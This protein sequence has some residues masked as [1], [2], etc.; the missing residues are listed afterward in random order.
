MH[1]VLLGTAGFISAI[2][3]AGFFALFV[4]IVFMKKN[5]ADM[6]R[7]KAS[8]MSCI[9]EETPEQTR[10]TLLASLTFLTLLL[11]TN[12][13]MMHLA[14]P[15]HAPTFVLGYCLTDLILGLIL[16]FDC[17]RLTVIH[18]RNIKA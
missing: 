2:L 13:M 15:G 5:V 6:F 7:K 1:T 10:T 3:V 11:V 4:G 16:I 9:V 14:Q 12:S 17:A 8:G 18:L